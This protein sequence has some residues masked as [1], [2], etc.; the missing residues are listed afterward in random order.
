MTAMQLTF[1]FTGAITLIAAFSVVFSPRLV[2]A[3]LWLILTLAGVAVLFVLLN[4]GFLA[5]V[6]VVV[7][8][9]AIA[10]LIVIVV[11]LTQRA[12]GEGIIQ[13]N[14]S[15]WLAAISV[16]I[17]FV[18]LLALL[19]LAP[20]LSIQAQPL[21]ADPETLLEDLGQSL[22]DVDRYILP[23]EMASILLLAALIGSIMIAWP[24]NGGEEKEWE[25]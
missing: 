20:S 14:R 22:V 10:I 3:A 25:R 12:M 16:L 9:D 21:T 2:H 17:L 8:I 19:N 23:F 11:M 13:V 5:V 18:G 6:Q 4:A 24:G 15:W 7:Y 1:L